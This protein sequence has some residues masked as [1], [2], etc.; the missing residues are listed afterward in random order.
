MIR[1]AE[2]KQI[3]VILD[4]SGGVLK[5]VLQFQEARPFAIKPNID[6]LNQLLDTKITGEDQLK[7]ALEH[8]LFARIQ[9]L[10]VSMG[11]QGAFV[12]HNR[13][14]FLVKIPRINVVNP[15]GSG[16][17]VVAGLAVSIFYK[18]NHARI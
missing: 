3:P 12:K 10:V 13:E 4:C 6:E 14:H 11:A 2:T 9:W 5:D 7:K 15:V 18:R 17:S 16:D 1:L 8:P